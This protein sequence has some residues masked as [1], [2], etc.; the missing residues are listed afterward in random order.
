MKKLSPM[1]KK[2][3]STVLDELRKHAQSKMNEKMKGLKKVT[4]ASDSE[5]G[6][7]KGLE[8]AEE[9]LDDTEDME[10]TEQED[11]S[12]EDSEDSY[13]DEDCD[14]P[15]EIDAKIKELLKLKD[16]MLKSK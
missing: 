1:E 6:L 4:V 3:S 15:E 8:K 16:E 12:P 10:E 14:T 11:V 13:D 5:E 9:V 7:K 2:A